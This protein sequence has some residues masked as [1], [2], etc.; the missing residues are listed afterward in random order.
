MAYLKDVDLKHYFR[1]RITYALDEL[2]RLGQDAARCTYL[3]TE[4]RR[5]DR[6]Q[7]HVK[8]AAQRV[9]DLVHILR[10][11]RVADDEV[12]QRHRL[13]LRTRVWRIGRDERLF[14]AT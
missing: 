10:G 4:L 2:C 11:G 14:F 13:V 9:H 8:E 6:E 5:H 12:L 1:L 3:E 7:A